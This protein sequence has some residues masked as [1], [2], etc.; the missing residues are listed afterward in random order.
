MEHPKQNQEQHISS[1]GNE[2][3]PLV[4]NINL[5]RG[6]VILLTLSLLAATFLGY[7]ALGQRGVQA[8]APQ[9]PAAGSTGLRQY[10]LT[11]IGYNGAAA[12][13]PGVCATGYHFASLWEIL[14]TTMLEYND[15]E[16]ITWDDLS[17]DGDMGEGPMAS[18]Y[19]WARTG[20]TSVSANLAGFSNCYAWD[21]SSDG[22]YGTTILLDGN[23]AAATNSFPWDVSTDTC[24]TPYYVW[25]VADY[26]GNR[27]YLPLVIK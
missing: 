22:Y 17:M 2:V 14:D 8:S 6:A 5:T 10:Y 23:W 24:D 11:K 19:G 13:E 9:A 4:I 20:N 16:G 7:L 18:M 12:D 3:E 21:S 25:C 27:V 26:I 1:Q 15:T